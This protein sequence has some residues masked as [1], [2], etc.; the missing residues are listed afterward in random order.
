MWRNKGGMLNENKRQQLRNER[1]REK[2]KTELRLSVEVLWSTRTLSQ[3]KF[4]EDFSWSWIQIQKR[5][6]LLRRQKEINWEPVNEHKRTLMGWLRSHGG[7][8]TLLVSD[9][10][11]A[12]VGS[13]DYWFTSSNLGKEQR[14]TLKSL[15]FVTSLTRPVPGTHS[16]VPWFIQMVWLYSQC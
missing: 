5:V 15:L 1:S 14:L 10:L 13:L 4:T 6:R 9:S 3:E 7:K 2:G 16:L 12:H 11:L 8:S